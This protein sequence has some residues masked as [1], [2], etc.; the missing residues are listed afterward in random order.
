MRER[1]TS[2]ANVT[3][4]SAL[5]L[6]INLMNAITIENYIRMCI[7]KQQKSVQ[8][9]PNIAKSKMVQLDSYSADETREIKAQTC[10]IELHWMHS[11]ALIPIVWVRGSIVVRQFAIVLSS[12][13]TRAAAAVAAAVVFVL[14]PYLAASLDLPSQFADAVFVSFLLFNLLVYQCLNSNFQLCDSRY[15]ALLSCSVAKIKW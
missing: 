11:A 7:F 10:E 3:A 4:S 14:L 15:N 6:S 8:F 13:R 5:L 12:I 1:D 9:I 2:V